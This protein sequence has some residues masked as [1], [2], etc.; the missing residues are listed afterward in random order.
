VDGP[1]QS[2]RKPLGQTRRLPGRGAIA[3]LPIAW[4]Y[5]QGPRQ[6]IFNL[7]LYQ[8]KYRH[9]WNGATGQDITALTSW[10]DSA[11]G[12]SLGLLAAAGLWFIVRDS[13]WERERRAEFYLALWLALGS[14]PKWPP[15]IPPSNA[16]S[17]W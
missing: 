8:L 3:W 13:G 17:F 5:R 10:I 7:V 9:K 15:P 11:Q 6:T 2:R 16:I 1:P 14:A 12:L 4:L